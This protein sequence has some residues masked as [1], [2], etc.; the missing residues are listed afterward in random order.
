M[1]VG[2]WHNFVAGGFAAEVA[3]HAEPSTSREFP[4]TTVQNPHLSSVGFFPRRPTSAAQQMLTVCAPLSSVMTVCDNRSSDSNSNGHVR[5]G[6]SASTGQLGTNSQPRRNSRQCW[7]SAKAPMCRVLW[8][9]R[10]YQV[11]QFYW[12][13][14][15]HVMPRGSSARKKHVESDLHTVT[16]S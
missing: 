6:Q 14:H 3:D 9:H 15:L 12:W 13:G 4:T 1:A 8:R 2:L 7:N 10:R 5:R 11:W 16:H